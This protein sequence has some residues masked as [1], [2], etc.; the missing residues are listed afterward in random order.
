MSKQLAKLLL[1]WFTEYP[2]WGM[3][4]GHFL[5]DEDEIPGLADWLSAHVV[6][7]EDVED[8]IMQEPTLKPKAKKW[9]KR[10]IRRRIN[11]DGSQ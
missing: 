5:L 11:Q 1:E 4:E 8:E 6:C 7:V 9:L 3:E 2:R 10:R